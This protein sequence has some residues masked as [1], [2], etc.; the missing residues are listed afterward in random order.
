MSR[1]RSGPTGMSMWVALR[2][3]S[4]GAMT[5]KLMWDGWASRP[6]DRARTSQLTGRYEATI[7]AAASADHG[8][9]ADGATEVANRASGEKRSLVLLNRTSGGK[10]W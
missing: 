4:C 2:L 6:R 3:T 5:L 9:A 10:P 7:K 8:K 1:E